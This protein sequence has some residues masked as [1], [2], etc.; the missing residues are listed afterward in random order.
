MSSNT[1]VRV[2]DTGE[3]IASI[4]AVIG[5]TPASSLVLM[6]M[7]MAS[8]QLG[9]TVRADL[10]PPDGYP[11][12]ARQTATPALTADDSAVIAVIIGDADHLRLIDALRRV[13][14]T[15]LATYHVAEIVA[16]ARW[17]D[18]L[19]PSVCGHL[20]DPTSTAA[21]AATA[22]EGSVV[23]DSRAE[24]DALFRPDNDQAIE[25]RA[26]LISE[27]LHTPWSTQ[28]SV[29]VVQS[30][31]R[32]SLHHGP[33]PLADTD[34]AEL[35]I[36]ISDPRVRDAC[37]ATALPINSPL[38]AAATRLWQALTRALPAPERAEVAVLAGVAAYMRGDGATAQI[39]LRTALRASPD[40]V[41][42]GLTLQALAHG[43]PPEQLRRVATHDEVGLCDGLHAK[44]TS[45]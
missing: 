29:S 24:I 18:L 21:R 14:V 40:H 22:V 5:F 44:S 1:T 17:R 37:L 19:D 34:V 23:Y 31:L 25:R 26:K 6:L 12:L 16:G 9:L 28:R 8:R 2:T 27:L 36:A 3:L 30:A 45:P 35:G 20:P 33:Q 32:R 13:G 38:A 42:A 43:M 10:T 15:L 4:P 39:A 7:S 41:L 11:E